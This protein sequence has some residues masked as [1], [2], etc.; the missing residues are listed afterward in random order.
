MFKIAFTLTLVGVILW[1]VG[2]RVGNGLWCVAAIAAFAY[3]LIMFALDAEEVN[4]PNDER[5]DRGDGN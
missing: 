2:E 1:G 4:A 3:A 5:W